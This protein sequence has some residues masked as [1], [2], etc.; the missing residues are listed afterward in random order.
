MSLVL[1]SQ[2]F[3][4][5]SDDVVDDDDDNDDDNDCPNLKVRCFQR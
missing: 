2:V 3:Q 1:S 5:D 4:L